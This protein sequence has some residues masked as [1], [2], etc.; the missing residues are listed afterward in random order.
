MRGGDSCYLKRKSKRSMRCGAYDIYKGAA[1]L[2][3]K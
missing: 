3:A 2:K 1:I